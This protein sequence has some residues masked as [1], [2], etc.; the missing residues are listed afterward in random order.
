MKSFSKSCGNVISQLE[1]LLNISHRQV[2]IHVLVRELDPALSGFLWTISFG[3]QWFTKTVTHFA[4][5]LKDANGEIGIL[6][7]GTEGI[8]FTP[9]SVPKHPDLMEV[10]NV[11][12]IYIS[13]IIDF[14]NAL[15]FR[16][17]DF[18]SYN[19]KHFVHDFFRDVIGWQINDF[20]DFCA[21]I[22][23]KYR[24]LPFRN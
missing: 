2:S 6:E 19:C 16:P 18:F 8:T 12:D 1:E 23:S 15:R 4:L 9:A 20:G 24:P 13:K 10:Q 5:Q 7:L 21:A 22:E 14:V 11:Q 3:N 17:Y